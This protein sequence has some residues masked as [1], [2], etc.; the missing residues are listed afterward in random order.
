MIHVLIPCC[1]SK[2]GGG[3]GQYKT[4]DVL[5]G[6]LKPNTLRY[7]MDCRRDLAEILALAPGPDLGFEVEADSLR[8]MPAL[9]RYSGNLYKSGSLDRNRINSDL[10]RLTIIS[11]LYGVIDSSDLVREY[12]LAM[13]TRLPTGDRVYRWWKDRRLGEIVEEYI[14]EG[15]PAAV[16]DILSI[17]Y[18]KALGS[19]PPQSLNRIIRIHEYPGKG[20]G[21][22]Y[23]RGKDVRQLL[24][25]L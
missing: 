3:V 17:N 4:S 2:S 12:E 1:Q 5:P 21:S 20:S 19:W 15:H 7:L 9:R 11:A 14:A 16:H 10:H 13:D 6:R 24:D 8:Y 25:E 23:Y 18:R 22:N